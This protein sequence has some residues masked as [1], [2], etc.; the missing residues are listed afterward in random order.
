MKLEIN[1]IYHNYII[2]VVIF[3]LFTYKRLIR[4]PQ[5]YKQSVYS[6]TKKRI[7]WK[8]NLVIDTGPNIPLQEEREMLINELLEGVEN[9]IMTTVIVT[10]MTPLKEVTLEIDLRDEVKYEE[11]LYG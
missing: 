11:F 2:R 1:E 10:F 8:I 3:S 6:F 5:V 4:Q 7:P 9:K